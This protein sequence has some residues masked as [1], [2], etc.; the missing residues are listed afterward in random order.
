[1]STLTKPNHSW[2]NVIYA[3]YRKTFH[4]WEKSS[5]WHRELENLA[6]ISFQM[7]LNGNLRCG[8]SRVEIRMEL[9]LI[10]ERIGKN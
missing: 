1:M 4:N 10:A 2:P 9:Y 8:F 7:N 6:D 5:F 3:D